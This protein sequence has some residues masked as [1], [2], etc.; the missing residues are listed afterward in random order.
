MSNQTHGCRT[1]FNLGKASAP[2]DQA[3]TESHPTTQDPLREA[4]TRTIV[5]GADHVC[6]G[7]PMVAMDT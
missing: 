4:G 1:E 7:I 5:A 2:H 6:H 3:P